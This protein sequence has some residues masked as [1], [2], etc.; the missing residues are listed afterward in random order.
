MNFYNNDQYANIN[1]HHQGQLECLTFKTIKDYPNDVRRRTP[2]VT[3]LTNLG[4]EPKV[5]TE[6]A[7]RRCIVH[8]IRSMKW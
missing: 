5:K 8:K 6:E 7:I 3:R 4:W 1:K 2:G